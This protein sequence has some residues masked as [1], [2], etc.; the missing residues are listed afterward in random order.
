[1]PETRAAKRRKL[2]GSERKGRKRKEGKKK[3]STKK[4]QKKQK[5]EAPT[6]R[7]LHAATCLVIAAN[8]L[9]C[10][11]EDETLKAFDLN[12][13]FGACIGISRLDRSC[14]LFAWLFLDMVIGIGGNVPEDFDWLRPR[15]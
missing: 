5:T 13:K 1:M 7:F 6:G 3:E 2:E 8:V 4:P 15:S 9:G 12:P 10:L 11:D 14:M